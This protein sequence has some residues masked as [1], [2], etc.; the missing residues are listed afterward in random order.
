MDL[1]IRYVSGLFDGEGWI[2]IVKQQLGGYGHYND[3]YVRYQLAIGIGMTNK[4]VIEK[5]HRQFGG[6][7]IHKRPNLVKLPK[8]R[9]AYMWKI[10]SQPAADFLKLAAPHMVVKKDEAEV[11]IEFQ[12][13]VRKHINDFRYK[14]ELRDALY[15]EREVFHRQLLVL[16]K[17]TFESPVGSDP[18]SEAA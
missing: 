1:D 13:H 5:M 12:K 17:R 6:G 2:T 4:P 15:A 18:M 8:A 11:A 16:K 3:H 9:L 10:T 14:P 7:F